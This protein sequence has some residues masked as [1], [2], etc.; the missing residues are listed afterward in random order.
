MRSRG[1]GVGVERGRWVGGVS[2]EIQ[3]GRPVLDKVIVKVTPTG[4]ASC[5][6]WRCGVAGSDGFSVCLSVCLFVV[7]TLG[8]GSGPSLYVCKQSLL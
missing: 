2:A 1:V 6:S 5:V 3:R 8:I 7:S 4:Q